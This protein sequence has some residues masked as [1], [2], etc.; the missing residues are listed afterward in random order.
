MCFDP[1]VSFEQLGK[2]LPEA[3]RDASRFEAKSTRKYLVARGYEEQ[4][5]VRYLIVHLTH[6]GCIGNKKLNY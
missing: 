1:N 4:N 3:A 6:D 2:V 5:V